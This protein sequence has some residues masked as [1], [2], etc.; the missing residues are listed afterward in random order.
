MKITYY[1][2]SCFSI[3]VNGKNLL[4]DPFITGNELA[5]NIDINRINCDYILISHGHG[6]HIGDAVAIAKRTGAT[7][8]SCYEIVEWMKTQGVEKGHPMNIGGKWPFDFGYVKCVIAIH[9]SVLPD[10]AYGGNP[11]GFI[12]ESSAGNFYFAGDT[13]LTY[14]MK[15][16]GEYRSG[17]DFAM[18]PIGGNFTMGVDNAV[19][20]AEFIKCDKIIGMHYDTFG[21]IKIDH[22]EARSKFARAGQ[23]LLLMEIGQSI[24]M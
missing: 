7:V 22:E 13:A 2:H 17:L 4:F 10:G 16:I 1:G 23:Q 11:M 15:L 19:I 5:K 12:I 14:D 3:E 20:A 9:S 18:L 21:Y 8:I 24:E 6:D